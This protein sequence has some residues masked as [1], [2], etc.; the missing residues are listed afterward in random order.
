MNLFLLQATSSNIG[1]ALNTIGSPI[2]Q[3]SDDYNLQTLITAIIDLV[4]VVAALTAFFFLIYGGIKWITSGGDKE[5][6]AAAQK[7][8][9]AAIIGLALAFSAWAI[10]NLV[11]G[12][13]GLNSNDINSSLPSGPRSPAGQYYDQYGTLK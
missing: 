7:T 9:T 8:L 3:A 13:F 1:E 5:Q 2:R 12:F 4:L 11:T 6:T 10:L